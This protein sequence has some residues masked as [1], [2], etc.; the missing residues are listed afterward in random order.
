MLSRLAKLAAAGRRGRSAGYTLTEVAI[1]SGLGIVVMLIVG[2][3]LASGLRTHAQVIK[4]DQVTSERRAALTV[5]STKLHQAELPLRQAYPTRVEWKLSEGPG[6]PAFHMLWAD[7]LSEGGPYLRYSQSADPF[8]GSLP[9]SAESSDPGEGTILARIRSCA[10][11][12][13]QLEYLRAP[14]VEG[15]TTTDEITFGETSAGTGWVAMASDSKRASLYTVAQAGSL[16]R[17]SAYLDGNGSG[18]TA[19]QAQNVRAFVYANN[20]GAPGALIGS[21]NAVAITKGRAGS[22]VEMS[23]DSP[24]AL[25]AG[26]YWIGLHTNTVSN[27][28]RYS[29]TSLGGSTRA[30]PDAYGDG[31]AAAYGS[32]TTNADRVLLHGDMSVTTSSSPGQIADPKERLW[33]TRAIVLNYQQVEGELVSLSSE[34]G[35]DGIQGSPAVIGNGDFEQVAAGPSFPGWTATPAS[36]DTSVETGHAGKSVRITPPSATG[37]GLL[38]SDYFTSS[39]DTVR[40]RVLAETAQSVCRVALINSAGDALSFDDQSAASAGVANWS[41][42]DVPLAPSSGQVVR[43][44]LSAQTSAC[45]FDSVVSLGR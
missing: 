38:E 15:G 16:R 41:N 32:T 21:T 1:A 36:V 7:C 5:V 23:F 3:L 17:I 27:I 8:A 25:A 34:N 31:T 4:K 24:P 11:E 14:T 33:L 20:S 9:P 40:V 43:L 45:Q 10:P 44:R 28:A 6:T 39:A 22:W 2:T 19:G 26:S 35:T 12:D 42:V 29:T 30:A 18:G 37:P 13:F